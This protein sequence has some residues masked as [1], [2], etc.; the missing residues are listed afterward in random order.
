MK[1]NKKSDPEEKIER[2]D[3]IWKIGGVKVEKRGLVEK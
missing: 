3:P 2:E 1:W